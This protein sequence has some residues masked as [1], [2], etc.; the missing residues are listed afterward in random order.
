MKLTSNFINFHNEFGVKKT[1]DIFAEA[2]FDGIEFNLDLEE[3]YT[4]AHGEE[5]YREI[6]EYAKRR[7]ISFPQAHAP[8]PSSYQDGE[9]N[10]KRFSEIVRSIKHA[11]WLGVG[12]LV[13]HPCKH[14]SYKDGDN[15]SLLLDYNLRFY[16]AL[17]PYAKQYGVKIAIENIGGS[18]TELGEGLI[19][20]FDTLA[21]SQFVVCYDIGH[22]NIIGH[23]SVE[24]IYQLGER[25]GC[26]HIHDNDGI[27]DLHTLPYYGNI[28]WE[29]AMR[30]FAEIGY[31]GNI[32]YEAGRFVT[33]VP[34]S[35]RAGS[36]AYMASVG[37]HLIERVNFYKLSLGEKK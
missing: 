31:S 11:S 15:Y 14:I 29:G 12:V 17:L 13:V 36:A 6:R 7:G 22:A 27:G 35:L 30:A 8:F 32:N 4:D 16:R 19:E 28:D 21:D 9:K 20:L 33:G 23:N 5:Y 26:T 37:R 25:I 1:I 24:M 2:G 34:V 3:Y 18:I 10:E